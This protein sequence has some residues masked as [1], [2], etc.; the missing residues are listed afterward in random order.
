MSGTRL[1][2][3]SSSRKVRIVASILCNTSSG[4]TSGCTQAYITIWQGACCILWT[5]QVASCCIEVGESP[6][7]AEMFRQHMLL[8]L[9]CFLLACILLQS[10]LSRTVPQVS[11]QVVHSSETTA[12]YQALM[13]SACF[14]DDYR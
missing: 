11:P 14:M 8:E 9:S 6:T 3:Q 4:A 13:Y 1:C 10:G 12:R 5:H 7:I 2:T